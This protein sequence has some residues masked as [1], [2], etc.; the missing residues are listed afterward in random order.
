MLGAIILN[1]PKTCIDRL[2]PVGSQ[3]MDAAGKM[4]AALCFGVLC[5]A[6]L[7]G[8]FAFCGCSGQAEQSLGVFAEESG[9]Y[10]LARLRCDE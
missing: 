8:R 1:L 7:P 4:L 10:F 3:V 2:G 9:P 6:L 5:F